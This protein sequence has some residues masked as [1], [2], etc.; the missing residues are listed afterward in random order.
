MYVYVYGKQ[1]NYYLCLREAECGGDLVSLGPGE[2]LALPELFLQLQQLL[3]R[4]GGPRPPVLTQQRVLELCTIRVNIQCSE[5]KSSSHSGG[6]VKW[7]G[8][9]AKYCRYA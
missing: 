9:L 3:R 8:Y 2:V 4:E 5:M 6:T 7:N 1:A